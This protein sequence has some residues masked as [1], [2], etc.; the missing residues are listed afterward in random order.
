[1][2]YTFPFDGPDGHQTFLR[3]NGEAV[4]E[5][6]RSLREALDHIDDIDVREN[7]LENQLLNLDAAE[8]RKYV[9]LLACEA[10]EQ[11][12]L[13]NYLLSH[14]SVAT[15]GTR[16]DYEMSEASKDLYQLLEGLSFA[17][18]PEKV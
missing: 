1:M 13:L 18:C 3:R 17:G 11:V 5:H 14:L 7:L 15:H 4:D 10:F 9:K 12:E 6:I 16:F 2:I 8:R